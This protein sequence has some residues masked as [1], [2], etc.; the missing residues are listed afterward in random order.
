M[1]Y[2]NELTLHTGLNTRVLYHILI[3]SLTL[4]TM[5]QRWIGI[6][7]TVDEGSS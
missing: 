4:Y 3:E 6:L 2:T 5:Y 1:Q 7:H